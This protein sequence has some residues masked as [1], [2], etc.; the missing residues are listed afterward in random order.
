[1]NP[2]PGPY[3]EIDQEGLKT[4]EGKK[5]TCGGKT[6]GNKARK[7][8]LLPVTGKGGESRKETQKEGAEKRTEDFN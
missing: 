2:H 5:G 8:R 4:K 6:A 1:L 3:R 7:T